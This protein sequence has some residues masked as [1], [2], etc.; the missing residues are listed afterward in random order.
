MASFKKLLTIWF[1]CSQVLFVSFAGAGVAAYDDLH[2]ATAHQ[3]ALDHH[4]HDD[5][6][7]HFEHDDGTGAHAHVVDSF[8]SFGL[9]QEN[10]SD[11]KLFGNQ[12]QPTF[13]MARPP[14]IYLGGPLR[15]PQTP[16]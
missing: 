1:L 7:S 13:L 2:V 6:S 11:L 3:A 4:H 9:I 14:D 16:L 8:Q 5:F 12:K 10:A 15:P